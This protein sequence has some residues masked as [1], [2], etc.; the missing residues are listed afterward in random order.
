MNTHNR[1]TEIRALVKR[2]VHVSEAAVPALRRGR[3]VLAMGVWNRGAASTDL[4]LAP[5]VALDKQPWIVR[6][7]YLQQASATRVVVRWRT[8]TPTDSR[9]LV[10]PDWRWI[11]PYSLVIGAILL[12]VADTLGRVVV[13]PDELQV[14]V[15]VA[16]VGAP[17]FVAQR[18]GLQDH[19]AERQR[20]ED[21]FRCHLAQRVARRG[22]L[23][24]VAMTTRARLLEDR[25]AIGRLLRRGQPAVEREVGYVRSG[26]RQVVPRPE[27]GLLAPLA[28]GEAPAGQQEVLAMT[29]TLRNELPR[30]LE[31]HKRIRAATEKLRSLFEESLNQLLFG[32]SC[33]FI[34]ENILDSDGPVR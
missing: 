8:D 23:L 15:I 16:L 13:R 33:A 27:G 14:G 3:N 1:G 32:H 20:I 17:F 22:V 4:L 19:P 30:M 2:S 12:V 5:V 11:L 24:S 6:G 25:L 34:G 10:G 31:E 9:V 21:G 7:P 28:R 29:D 26:R 18:R